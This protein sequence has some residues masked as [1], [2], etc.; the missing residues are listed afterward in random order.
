MSN[1]NN[2]NNVLNNKNKAKNKRR[3][4]FGIK[5]GI[6][7]RIRISNR[8][9]N[10][11][12]RYQPIAQ[13]RPVAYRNTK[14][15]QKRMRITRTDASSMSVSGMDLVYSIPDLAIHNG[16][17]VLSIIPCNPAYWTGTRISA[18][19]TGYQQFRPLK[20]VVHYVPIVGT[21]QQGNIF[22]GTIWG[23]IS[24][25]EENLQQTLVTSSGG[26]STQ[27]Y[28]PKS[29]VVKCGDNLKY[30]LY[31]MAGDL[32]DTSNPF[33]YVSIAVGNFRDN[34]R[35]TPGFIWVSYEFVFKNPIGNNIIYKNA[36][37]TEF[38][39]IVYKPNTTA[40]L[41]KPIK[42]D[43]QNQSRVLNRFTEVQINTT[44]DGYIVAT[45][46]DD[47]V[48]IQDEQELWVFQNFSNDEANTYERRIF[49]LN[50][51][52]NEPEKE[53][54]HYVLVAGRTYVLMGGS[55]GKDD[56]LAL[57]TTSIDNTQ[58]AINYW[59]KAAQITAQEASQFD[60]IQPD[61]VKLTEEEGTTYSLYF[62]YHL[63]TKTQKLNVT[64][65][66]IP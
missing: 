34:V 56:V 1:N 48:P 52:G 58:Y 10:Q 16:S 31:N 18:M 49:D 3:R 19:A 37:P 32:D 6:R 45:Y 53:E 38:Q 55:N 2:N 23:N 14:N 17:E 11:F 27:V 64:F 43:V 57:F 24:I 46:D 4:G 42:Y 22:G 66:L 35:I 26:M 39:D 9:R 51:G 7:N 62:R 28:Q 36:G 54:G 12:I 59:H 47:F 61:Q 13:Q 15:F 8:R 44:D 20:F 63:I 33:Y 65:G 25:P 5:R 41:L 29:A 30:N 50:F 40:L 21:T 60:D